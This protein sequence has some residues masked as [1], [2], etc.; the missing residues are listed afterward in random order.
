MSGFTYSINFRAV[1][2]SSM[3]KTLAVLERIDKRI[4]TLNYDVNKFGNNLTNA[5]QRGQ[6]AFGGM[7]TS[8]NGLIARLGIAALTL[9]SI[10]TAAQAEGLNQS[11]IFASGG[12]DQG[13]RNI[14]FLKRQSED[15]GLNYIA[16]AQ[17]Y[18]TM[19]ASLQGTKIEGSL[20]DIFT[21][22]SEGSTVLGMTQDQVQGTYIALGQM[23]SKGKVM[24]EELRGQLAERIPGA[25]NIAARAM[26]MTTIELNKALEDGKVYSDVF[27]PRFAAEMHK[28]FGSAVPQ[29]SQRAMANLNRFRN[30]TYDLNVAF[31]DQLLPT[32]TK[33]LREYIIPGI[34]W[35]KEHISTVVTL[36]GAAGVAWTAYKAWNLLLPVS[37]LLTGKLTFS[38]RALNAAIASNP[39]GLLVSALI[40]LGS[41]FVYA[42]NNNEK[43]RGSIEGLF[44]G[45]GQ[46]KGMM[47]E[48]TGLSFSFSKIL[49]G[50]T[51]F[52]PKLLK[53]GI[54][55]AK[56]YW[57]SAYNKGWNRGVDKF[58]ETKV[59]KTGDALSNVFGEGGGLSTVGGGLGVD[60]A[61]KEGVNAITGGGSQSRNIT[62]NLENLVRELTIQ[63]QTVDKGVDQMVDLVKRKLLQTLNTANQ[64]Q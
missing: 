49:I 51:T 45:L 33:F 36:A 6:R 61:L 39:V 22:V 55:E 3:A 48:I 52:N 23:A 25:F 40:L 54:Q 53:T 10:N 7:T 19:A 43:F 41:A 58:R 44:T 21:A 63:A 29:A 56:A 16:A 37:A 4:E 38:V 17:G 28:T 26:G 11:I 31:G 34:G 59:T 20:N 13:A 42:F 50:L 60:N 32:V 35:L 9:N 46:L 24:A 62:I 14:A 5:G 15:L 57:Q 30:A 8:V 1:Q 2:E 18:K 64:I 12:T 27:L 47:N